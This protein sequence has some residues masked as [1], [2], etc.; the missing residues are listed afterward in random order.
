MIRPLPAF[1]A[2]V[3]R[4]VSMPHSLSVRRTPMLLDQSSGNLRV[5]VQSAR[6]LE[7]TIANI[8]AKLNTLHLNTSQHHNTATSARDGSSIRVQAKQKSHRLR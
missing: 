5:G 1:C 6:R 4:A 8:L 2:G 7:A 3:A